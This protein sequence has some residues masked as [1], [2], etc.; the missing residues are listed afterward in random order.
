MYT[1]THSCVCIHTYIYTYTRTHTHA[2][3][4]RAASTRSKSANTK[5]RRCAT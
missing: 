3:Y 2:G 5:W 1:C 4:V